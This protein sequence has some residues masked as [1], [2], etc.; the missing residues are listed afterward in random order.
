[1]FVAKNRNGPDGLVYPMKMD[2]ANVS[3][4]VLEPDGNTIQEINKDAAKQQKQRL[5]DK[6]KKFREG[7]G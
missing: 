4:E 1:M 3:L 5:K 6:Y 7:E 2:T